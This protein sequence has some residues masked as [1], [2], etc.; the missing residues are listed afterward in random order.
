M[1]HNTA[2]AVLYGVAHTLAS[3]GIYSDDNIVGRMPHVIV[4]AKEHRDLLKAAGWSKQSIK[5]FIAEKAIIP[6]EWMRQVGS[7]DAPARVVD[8]PDDL[9]IVAAGGDA[10]RFAGVVVGWSHQSQPVT[11]AVE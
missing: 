6:A 5:E 9:L 4:F 10:G 1:H 8:K 11:V 2:E 3:T 7:Q